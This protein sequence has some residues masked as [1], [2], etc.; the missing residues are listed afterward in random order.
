MRAEYDIA[1]KVWIIRVGNIENNE[2]VLKNNNYE[3]RRK[4]KKG[5]KSSA[6]DDFWPQQQFS[7]L[8]SKI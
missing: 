8:F 7:G 6:A 5:N 4:I 3:L 2:F 1:L